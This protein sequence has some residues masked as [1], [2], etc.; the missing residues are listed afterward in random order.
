M[1]TANLRFNLPNNGHAPLSPDERKL[2][3]V[4]TEEARASVRLEGFETPIEL[5]K[6]DARYV[7][8]ELNDAEFETEYFSFLF[9]RK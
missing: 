8:G 3:F 2:R 6:I 9:D 4:A 1:P 5:D 7:A